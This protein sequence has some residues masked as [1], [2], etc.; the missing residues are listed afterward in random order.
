MERGGTL[1]ERER[2]KCGAR[3]NNVASKEWPKHVEA[4]FRPQTCETQPAPGRERV[5]KEL[6]VMHE[7][8]S[9]SL[10]RAQSR[11]MF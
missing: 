9:P 4:N 6:T 10:E 5:K 11:G 2:E 7:V 1:A 3:L 8:C